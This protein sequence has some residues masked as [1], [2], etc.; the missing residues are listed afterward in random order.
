MSEKYP[1]PLSSILVLV[2]KDPR[3][4]HKKIHD[5]AIKRSQIRPA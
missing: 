3:S 1:P 4:G 5:Q 2:K